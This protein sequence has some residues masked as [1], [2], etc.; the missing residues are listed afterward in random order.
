[1]NTTKDQQASTVVK[2]QVEKVFVHYGLPQRIHSDQGR[3]FENKLIRRLLDLL[4]IQK[5]RTTPYHLQGD[6]Q[7]EQCNCTI[8]DMLSMLPNQKK[9][10]WM[11]HILA[12][13]HA[14]KQHKERYHR[15]HPLHEHVWEGSPTAGQPSILHIFTPD[16]KHIL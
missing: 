7:P 16:F 9:E 11:Q 10:H 5:S 15:V 2:V 14:Y 12:V 4:G 3:D 8:L 6:P 13:E 1:M